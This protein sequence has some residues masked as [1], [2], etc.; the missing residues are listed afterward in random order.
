MGAPAQDGVARCAG[1]WAPWDRRCVLPLA[2]ILVF[3]SLVHHP[4]T[5]LWAETLLL[6]HSWC[7]RVFMVSSQGTEFVC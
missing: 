1:H 7:Q 3:F 2:H 5:R 4:G 6:G